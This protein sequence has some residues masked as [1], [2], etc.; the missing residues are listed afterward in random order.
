MG[1]P[2]MSTI[3]TPPPLP[4][5][6]LQMLCRPPHLLNRHKRM[7]TISD[8]SSQ[9][10]DALKVDKERFMREFFNPEPISLSGN[11]Y[12]RYRV[13]GGSISG[14]AFVNYLSRPCYSY[15]VPSVYGYSKYITVRKL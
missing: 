2:Q 1:I 6:P 11:Y 4:P 12:P 13:E 3:T 10:L 8:Q 5:F 7:A 9:L 14:S 15:K